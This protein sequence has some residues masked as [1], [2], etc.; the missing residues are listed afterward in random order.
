[1]FY[2]TLLGIVQQV[3]S[4]DHFVIL[5]DLNAPASSS[6]RS[7]YS[8]GNLN[9][10]SQL[11]E[12]LLV[13]IDGI[14]AE[15]WLK[16]KWRQRYTF[17]GPRRREAWLDH[18]II[19]LRL[20]RVV[21]DVRFVR[22]LLLPSD[23][24]LVLVHL[25]LTA[26]LYRPPQQHQ[27]PLWLALKDK[28]VRRK[29][30][31]AVAR[32]LWNHMP[33]DEELVAAIT[34]V[35]DECL[36]KMRRSPSQGLP[37]EADPSVQR[38]RSALRRA[39][40]TAATGNLQQLEKEYA[41]SITAFLQRELQ[42]MASMDD[43]QRYH[44]VWRSIHRLTGKKPPSTLRLEGTKPE[45][46]KEAARKYFQELLSPPTAM[47]CSGTAPQISQ[48]SLADTVE[49]D[50]SAIRPREVVDVAKKMAPH[51]AAGSDGIPMACLRLPQVA[52]HAAQLMN[53]TLVEGERVPER[54]SRAILVPVPKKAGAHALDQHR[55]IS[56][57]NSVP[58]LFNRILLERVQKKVE[59]LLRA[60]Q[61]GFRP[62]RSTIQHVL[63]LR[64]ITEEA[65]AHKLEA[66]LIFVDYKKAFDSVNRETLPKLLEAYGIPPKLRDAI[67]AMYAA[68]S[69]IVRTTDGPTASFSTSTGVLQGDS[70]APFLFVLVMDA[71]I[72][73][74]FPND[75]DG[76]VLER[77]RSSKHLGKKICVLLYA[78]DVVLLSSTAEGAQRLL[79]RL[80][81]L[82]RPFGLMINVE[83][84][85]SISLNATNTVSFSTSTGIVESCKQFTY[86]GC[87][88]PSTE[89]DMTRRKS[90]AW[91]AMAKLRPLWKAPIADQVKGRLFS[92]LVETIFLYGSVTWSLSP[93]LEK[94]LDASHARL[95][96][97]A[98]GKVWPDKTTNQELYLLAGVP[99]P[100][101]TLR[102][103]RR[104]IAQ[105]I[106]NG[107]L[108]FLTQLSGVL[109][110]CPGRHTGCG[111]HRCPNFLDCLERD[112]SKEKMDLEAWL[113]K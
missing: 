88:I 47:A 77:R 85:K 36:P 41:D 19:P 99:K 12:D 20:G 86:L 55:G 68:P 65:T 84:T 35:A 87:Q 98:L 67:C 112:A 109:F 8:T 80:E 25:A 42:A 58:K 57:L 89:Q 15:A 16:K 45:E 7:P 6:M 82:S 30:D 46:R 5:G 50:E 72:R 14:T 76:F 61:N 22:P 27:R 23:H 83:K 56:L 78:D 74:A 64:R 34:S 92:M 54:W 90:L 2:D 43:D 18:I 70:M 40:M 4:R 66:H 71:I 21:R 24:K 31:V 111:S 81:E 103:K 28:A 17:A 51:K 94:Q 33:D 48:V 100:S 63:A 53:R 104:D 38:A 73:C 69:A 110:W 62:K 9:E 95:L 91:C 60:E 108:A 11:L 32:Q 96:R 59:P 44:F 29:F 13:G 105:K 49:F 1:M 93:S 101:K 106:R 107:E 26:Q 102:G 37:W 10:N 79:T 75:D 52:R 97:H 3:P 39:R 113:S